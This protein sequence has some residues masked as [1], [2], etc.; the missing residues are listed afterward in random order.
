MLVNA[1]LRVDGISGNGNTAV[2]NRLYTLKGV[3]KVNIDPLNN[4]VTVRFD[5]GKTGLVDIKQAILEEG[6]TVIEI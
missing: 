5:Q 4:R 2:K 3:D 6:Y 1:E